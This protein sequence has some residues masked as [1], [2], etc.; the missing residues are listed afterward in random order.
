[1]IIVGEKG[2]EHAVDQTRSEDFII[3]GAAFALE[4]TTG[5][6]TV[7]REFFFVLDCQRHEVNTFASFLG[8]NDRG[9]QHGVAHAE[10]YRSISLL[11]KFP[12]LEGNLAAVSKR[13]GFFDWIHISFKNIDV[14]SH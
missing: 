12:G 6:T 8:R 14:A 5:E 9:K 3:A 4:E 11:C 1:M 10:F 13:D 2:T 7:G